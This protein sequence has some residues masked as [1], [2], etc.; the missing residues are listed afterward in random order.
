MKKRFLPLALSFVVSLSAFADGGMW[1]MQ[2]MQAKYQAMKARGLEL[3]AYD[4]YNPDGS[5]LKD[6]VI[7]FDNGC[8]GAVVS[9]QGL[10]LTNHHCGYDQ[11]Q[12]HSSIEHN[13]LKDGFWAMTQAEE[14]PNPGL[15]VLFIDQITD[16]TTEVKKELAK[17]KD[18]NSMDYLSPR[19]LSTLVPG[20]VGKK[21][22]KEQG[23]KYL[24]KAFYGGNQYLMFKQ[25]VYR[26]IRLVGAPPSSIG[27]F[28]E[29]T[30][31]WAWPRHSGDF[32]IFRIYADK[33]GRPADYSPKNIPLKPKRYFRISTKGITEGDYA[34]IMGFPGTT[35]H[36]FTPAEVEE[37]G[38]LD[39]DI[40]IRMR[41]IRQEVMLKAMLADPQIK[42]MYAAKYASS[43]NGY[44]RAQGAN[45]AIT[46]RNLKSIKEAQ[47]KQLLDW[48]EQQ[49]EPSYAQAVRDIERIVSER[50]DLRTRQKYLEETALMGIEAT[51]CRLDQKVIDDLRDKG[52]KPAEAMEEVKKLFE[53]F[54]NKDYSP[55]LDAAIAKAMLNEYVQ[56]IAYDKWPV[57][58]KE[59]SDKY[60]NSVDRYVD[61]MFSGSIFADRAKFQKAMLL[62]PRELADLLEADPILRYAA[63]VRQEY[64]NVKKQLAP[65]D[66]PLSRAQE[67]YIAG[68]KKMMPQD[69]IWPDANLTLRFTFGQMKGYYPKDNVYYG[70]QTT[71]LG[72]M[73]KEDPNNWE[74]N[75]SDKLKQL[76]A[77]KD[78]GQY[79]MSD[80]RMPVNFC[81]TTHTT[82]GNSGSPVFNSK[83]ELIGLN[84]DRN[85]EGVGGDIEYLPEYQRSII[86]DIRY[87]LFVIDKYAGCKRLIS[88][89]D[90]Q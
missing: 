10:L 88:E 30:D 80:G 55:E 89:M 15:E 79:A 70:P 52:K 37:W 87:L 13:Y 35:Y 81:A 60:G 41:N 71:L 48:A 53:K 6:A 44:K 62:S 20:I 69:Q 19:Y 51:K 54:Y 24:I 90:L 38:T 77:N 86:C 72:V 8:T 26:D 9:D 1:L 67:I 59:I 4:L 31:N 29:D 14:L 84:F 45:W 22:M 3:E 21:A 32:S 49:R 76:Y 12:S 17:I 7:M 47:T 42:I 25:L 40:R 16:V 33:D 74:Y 2:Q 58:L 27:K 23:V 46:K 64:D 56:R 73:E 50:A 61:E 36:F 75:V 39:N 11:I 28:G 78:F 82:G 43:Q 66:A 85:W 65:Y 5:S 68:M 18:P 57:A 63:S 83:G 34:M